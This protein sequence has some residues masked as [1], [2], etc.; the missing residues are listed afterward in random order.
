MRAC[1]AAVIALTV[2]IGGLP[3]NALTKMEQS[4][5]KLDPQERAHQA[6]VAKGLEVVRRDKRLVHADRLVP[7]VLKRAQFADG[8]VHA[9]GAAVRTGKHWYA[10][11]FECAVTSDQLKA[12]SFTFNLGDEIPPDTWDDVGL[13]R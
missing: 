6:C 11:S 2:C 4:L 7:D 9:K 1:F 3:A 13:W 5:M 8:V 12:T 10:L